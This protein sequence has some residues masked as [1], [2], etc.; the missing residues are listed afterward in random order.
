MPAKAEPRSPNEIELRPDG[1]ERFRTAV[2][3]AAKKGPMHRTSAK[4]GKIAKVK[5]A[6]ADEKK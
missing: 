2:H 5:P 1:W 6:K 4:L 3:A